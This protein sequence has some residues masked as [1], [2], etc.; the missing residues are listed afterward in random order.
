[1]KYSAQGRIVKIVVM[2]IIATLV[3]SGVVCAVFLFRNK[4]RDEEKFEISSLDILYDDEIVEN[5][6]VEVFCKDIKFDAK[7]ND[8]QLSN[9]RIKPS[10]T[11]E[12]VGEDLNCLVD[13]DGLVQ[14]GNVL[15]EITLSCTVESSNKM[16][17]TLPIKITKKAGSNLQRLDATVNDGCSTTYV[18]GQ[19]F[20]KKSISVVGDFGEYF[21]IIS[22]FETDSDILDTSMTEI[23]ITF[24][25]QI[26][27]MPI[28]VS[29][30]TLKDIE[31]IR[32][33]NKINYVEGQTFDKTGLK[34]KAIYDACEEESEAIYTNELSALSTQDDEVE[35]F[36][37]FDGVIKS[38]KQKIYVAKRKL[39]SLT[40]NCENIQKQYTQ[41]EKF[42][43]SG[44]KVFANFEELGS[45]E[46]FDYVV[47]D[48]ILM[49]DDKNIDVCFTEYGVTKIAQIKDLIVLKP[50]E[51]I[52]QVEI[53]SPSDVTL[54]WT[55][56]YFD[57]EKN[58][59][60]DNLTY[61]ENDLLFDVKNGLYEIPVGAMVTISALNPAVV[62]FVFDGEEQKMDYPNMTKIWEIQSGQN[63]KIETTQMAGERVSISFVGDNKTKNFL[64]SKTWNA[65]LRNQDIQ[66]LFLV[67]CDCDNS[68]YTYKIDDI[69]YSASELTAVAFNKD[70]VVIVE[71]HQVQSNLIA[72]N[73]NYGNDLQITIMVDLENYSYSNL[74]RP[75]KIGYAFDGWKYDDDTMVS[76]SNFK[77]F[78]QN[79]QNLH[80]IFAVWTKETINYA[81]E[82]IVGS[83]QCEIVV[84][85]KSVKC[86]VEFG[87]DATFSYRVEVDGEENNSF[88]GSY[89]IEEGYISI[90]SV[91]TTGDYML[92][93]PNDFE[94]EISAGMLYSTIFVVDQFTLISTYA[95][96][97]V[98]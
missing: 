33:P 77:S 74:P 30:K 38:A 39:L 43:P 35:I 28:S 85:E 91:E 80:Q 29:R 71:K 67:F 68:Y 13:E 26:F 69:T 9:Y 7:I 42:N 63:L 27:I 70:T 79:S 14:I 22:N 59:H 65:P 66:K 5:F 12:I 10:I 55:Y 58:E 94:F 34:I 18:E 73:L 47:E 60:I 92:L 57:D 82:D 15:G 51:E 62:D 2:I 3:V 98:A 81:G 1:M 24:D 52:C 45:I 11:W 75:T 25:G 32:Q 31:I 54:A 41:G 48:K 64:Y 49:G 46:I 76:E 37:E 16:T 19:K 78:L 53:A 96:L 20:D 36:F 56:S 40:L 6:D 95:N 84:E 93:S 89:R 4:T 72:L 50:Y 61:Q 86:V 90:I 21:A 88:V 44:L 97:S 17:K 87:Q 8:V 83:W 23:A